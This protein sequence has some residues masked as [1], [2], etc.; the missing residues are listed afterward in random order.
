M[1]CIYNI[2]GKKKKQKKTKKTKNKP[3]NSQTIARYVKLFLGMCGIEIT[4]F[5]AHSTRIAS[6]STANNMGLSIKDIQKATGWSGI[7]PF[8]STITYQY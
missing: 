5:T 1:S 8:S 3:V 4:I 7:V 2:I 6:T